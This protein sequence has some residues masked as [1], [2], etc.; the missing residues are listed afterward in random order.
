MGGR[1]CCGFLTT[2]E[3]GPSELSDSPSYSPCGGGALASM[4]PLH[5][6]V[7][8]VASAALGRWAMLPALAILPPLNDR[9]GLAKLGSHTRGRQ[10]LVASLWALPGVLPLAWLSPWRTVTALAGL[11]PRPRLR[12]VCPSPD[13]RHDGRLPRMPVLPGSNHGAALR[14]AAILGPAIVNRRAAPHR[15]RL[16]EESRQSRG[17]GSVSIRRLGP[18][19][20]SAS[21]QPRSVARSPG[22]SRP[23]LSARCR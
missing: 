4:E 19:S 16:A 1:T 10:V 22:A 21:F 8:S 9:E 23:R 15:C 14:R 18:E 17:T 12:L 11:A 3:S 7:A 6:I 13:R 2:A 5:L 20:P